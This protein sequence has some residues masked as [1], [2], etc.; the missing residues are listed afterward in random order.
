[1]RAST[2]DGRR[3]I[4]LTA[5][6]AALLGARG[7]A[8]QE[9]TPPGRMIPVY[10]AQLHLHCIGS[11]HPAIVLEA[12]LGGNY[13]DWT[14][15]Q[16]ELARSLTAC[17]YDRAGAGF[18]SRTLRQRTI[19]NISGELHDLVRAGGVARPFVLVGHSFGGMIAMDYARRYPDDVAGLVL[20]DSMHPDQFA[21]FAG[22]GV[23]L[24]MD[25]R[26]VLGRTPPDAAAYG[27]PPD[28]RAR[29][30]ALAASDTAR[31]F[32]VRE[33][34]LMPAN[35]ATLRDEGLPRLPAR[36]LVH[37]NDEWG[38]VPPKGQMET[39]WRALQ[40]DLAARLGAP[41]PIV[42]P[43]SGHQIALDAP[44]VVTAAVDDLVA[45]LR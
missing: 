12:G 4:A 17:S 38:A 25:P 33:M 30:V 5:L 26:R 29:A 6:A 45:T 31:V 41:A 1:V 28:L 44:E 22:A 27:M 10:D 37:G 14:K 35:A 24:E 36:V 7:S 9:F 8:A 11:G 19:A 40:I 43:Q 15:V 39:V 18:S 23:Q 42:V 2:S 13:L 20:L 16:P 21:Q 34:L 3:L 32:V